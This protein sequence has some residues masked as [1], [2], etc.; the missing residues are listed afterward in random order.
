MTIII[1]PVGDG[2]LGI[3][4]LSLSGEE[5]RR[6]RDESRKRLGELI[7]AG[8]AEAVADALLTTSVPG[9]IAD[10]RFRR[11]PVSLILRALKDDCFSWARK[12]A[13]RA[14][15]LTRRL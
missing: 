14:A 3:D 12:P 6:R 10:S 1:H 8:R 11:T 15:V 5:K 9:G 7:D 13:W 2:D 4:I